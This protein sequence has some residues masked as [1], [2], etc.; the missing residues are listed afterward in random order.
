MKKRGGGKNRESEKTGK[1]F[2]NVY[3]N[4]VVFHRDERT[5]WSAEVWFGTRL[6]SAD[7]AD[8]TTSEDRKMA[9]S[10]CGPDHA[11][12]NSFCPKCGPWS[13]IWFV[14]VRLFFFCFNLRF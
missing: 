8:R 2:S 4:F 1:I 13:A 3:R 11:D 5:T 6:W 7:H 9:H 14:V 10:Q 12:R